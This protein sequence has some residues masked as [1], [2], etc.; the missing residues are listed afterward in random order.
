MGAIGFDEQTAAA[1][2]MLRNE[3][4]APL[5]IGPVER[6]RFCAPGPLPPRLA[7]GASVALLLTCRSDLEGRL[8]ERVVVRSND[9]D[10]AAFPIDV[11]G[12]VVPS[13]AFDVP[14][15]D[16]TTVFGQ[17]RAAEA[18]LVGRRAAA[19]RLTL[20]SPLPR[21]ISVERLEG[22]RGA[23]PGVRLHCRARAAGKQVGQLAFATALDVPREIRLSW[24]CRVEGTL[25]VVPDNVS[26][27]L[28]DGHARPQ[29]VEVRSVQPGFALRSP[30]I[31]SGPFA[32][33]LDPA[34]PG[35]IEVT[36]TGL[37]AGADRDARG[38][39]GALIVRSNDRGEPRRR[40]PLLGFGRAAPAP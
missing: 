20:A 27:D 36:F 37:P 2:I 6:S 34:Q 24:V 31:E 32:A 40:V 25:T 21:D 28:V 33:R 5:E 19:A 30:R 13:L 1:S 35:R 10:A 12:T 39:T 38:V 22:A 23:P 4:R 8:R 15:I 11:V 9:P 26:F 3:G 16:I 17:A 14:S 18:R 7:P 29:I